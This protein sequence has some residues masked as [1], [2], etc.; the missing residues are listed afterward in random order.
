MSGLLCLFTVLLLSSCPSNATGNAC[1]HN[2][3]LVMVID[4]FIHTVTLTSSADILCPGDT[5]VFTCVTDTGRLIWELINPINRHS[6][7]SSTQ[8]P[9]TKDIFTL[10]LLNVTNGSTYRSTATAHNIPVG[11]DGTAVSCSDGPVL[12]SNELSVTI[13]TLY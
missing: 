1:Q 13:S 4:N 3:A 10:A 11:Y 5:V 7:H 8:N 6:F 12:K 9:V 2:Y